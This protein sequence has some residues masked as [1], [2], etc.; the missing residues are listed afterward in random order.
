MACRVLAAV[1][2]LGTAALLDDTLGPDGPFEAF[3]AFPFLV[4]GV[5]TLEAPDF[6][7]AIR[8]EVLVALAVGA[9][10]TDK[11]YKNETRHSQ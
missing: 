6:L 11:E 3:L 8:A 1:G 5:A 9:I 7:V 4:L 2:S 10:A